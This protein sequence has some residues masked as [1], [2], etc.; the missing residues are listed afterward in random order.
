M[1]DLVGSE[2]ELLVLNENRLIS[3]DSTL[4]RR[5]CSLVEVDISIYFKKCLVLPYTKLIEL[6]QRKTQ[7]IRGF[8]IKMKNLKKQIDFIFFTF[9]NRYYYII[10]YFSRY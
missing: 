10:Y 2:S 4:R 1:F 9:T 7:D 8:Y 5:A 6:K 3:S